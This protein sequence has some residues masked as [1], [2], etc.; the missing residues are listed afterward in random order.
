MIRTTI[1]FYDE[2]YRKLEERKERKGLSSIAQC[3]RDL[4]DLALKIEEAAEQK[5]NQE[6]GLSDE[7]KALRE[8]KN[9]LKHDLNWSMESRLLSRYLV[10]QLPN[11]SHTPDM[12]NQI[13]ERATAHVQG[14]L[15]EDLD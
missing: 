3:I 7:M 6:D 12:L 14:L 13:K 10:E 9:L 8:L 4:V 5:S 2:I 15:Q 1:T 11:E